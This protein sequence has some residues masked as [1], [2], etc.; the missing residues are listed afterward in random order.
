MEDTLE[1]GN[2]GGE[3]SGD[4]R[5]EENRPLLGA[6][7]ENQVEVRWLSFLVVFQFLHIIW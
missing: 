6:A 2:E 1:D 5:Q 4:G 3:E 7:E